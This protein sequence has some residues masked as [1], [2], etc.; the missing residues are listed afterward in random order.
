M[1]TKDPITKHKLF[2]YIWAISVSG[3]VFAQIVL[4]KDH[5][6]MPLIEKALDIIKLYPLTEPMPERSPS[7]P[8]LGLQL[9]SGAPNSSSYSTDTS[10]QY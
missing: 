5:R 10:H 2:K 9:P 6:F 7:N 4:D 3:L 1:T 8:S